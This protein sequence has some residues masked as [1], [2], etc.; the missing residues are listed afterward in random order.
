MG[1]YPSFYP[2]PGPLDDNE[3]ALLLL[4]AMRA[5]IDFGQIGNSPKDRE[6]GA[7]VFVRQNIDKTGW[8]PNTPLSVEDIETILKRRQ[9]IDAP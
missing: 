6:H 3:K 7:T 9:D 8:I 2:E 4:M 5:F 1:G